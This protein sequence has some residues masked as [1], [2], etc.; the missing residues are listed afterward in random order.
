MFEIST[1]AQ[2][3]TSSNRNAHSARNNRSS[4]SNHNNPHV[5][6]N[7][8]KN[9]VKV[10]SVPY[11]RPS[12]PPVTTSPI[13]TISPIVLNTPTMSIPTTTIPNISINSSTTA[14]TSISSTREKPCPKCKESTNYMKVLN[15]R[16]GK[17]EDLVKNLKNVTTQN[18]IKREELN[19]ASLSKNERH[20][21]IEAIDYS[22]MS[23]ENLQTYVINLK[24]ISSN[25]V[26][27]N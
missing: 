6:R 12:Q 7:R 5:M 1:A 25:L 4:R 16:V 3:D 26:L 23:L 10:E 22:K 24:N 13:T 9:N 27:N 21:K 20:S 17:L 19:N 2:Y 11:H 14:T 8:K 15:K 18:N